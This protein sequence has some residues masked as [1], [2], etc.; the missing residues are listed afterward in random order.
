MDNAITAV[1]AFNRFYTRFAGALDAHYMDSELSL[2]EARLLYE[3][4]NR[5]A[6]LAMDLQAEL[7]LDPGYVS[8]ILRRFQ[9]KGWIERGRG[10][11]GRQRPIR[12]TGTGRAYFEALNARTRAETAARMG[13]LSDGEQDTLIAA[14]ET[15]T[16][17]LSGREAPWH[18]RTFR[19]GDLHLI[20]SRQAILY[21]SYGW[22]RPMEVLQGEVTTA[23]LRDFKPGREQCWVAERAGLMAGAILL[24]DAGDNIGQLRLLHVETWARGLGIGSALVEECVNFARAAGYDTIRLWTHTVLTPARRIYEKA[25]FRI[26]STEVHHE[27]GKPEQG[28]TWE[29]ALRD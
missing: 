16:A 15:V 12:L 24:V 25:G 6:P 7:G 10:E 3:I 1:R 17:L 27:F 20:A 22:K 29:L 28:E 4:A 11:D 19:T 5:E 13:A 23:F 21:E 9:A 26:V 14:L 18:I 2:A 8:R